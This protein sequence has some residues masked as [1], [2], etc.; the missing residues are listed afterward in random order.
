MYSITNSMG[1]DWTAPRYSQIRV[2]M[3][4]FHAKYDLVCFKMYAAENFSGNKKKWQDF[5]GFI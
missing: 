4:F 5:K 2:N 3:D 1:P